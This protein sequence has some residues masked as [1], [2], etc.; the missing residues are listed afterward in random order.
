MVTFV[1]LG[2]SSSIS[3]VLSKIRFSSKM[4]LTGESWASREKEIT[5]ELHKEKI[6]QSVK[7]K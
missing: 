5:R 3:R 7:G 1:I 6:R 4:W 2:V